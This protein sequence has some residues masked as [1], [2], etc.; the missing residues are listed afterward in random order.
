MTEMATP[1]DVP[2][3]DVGGC[4][5]M[6]RD[7]APP[8]P[9]GCYWDLAKELREGSPVYFNTFAQG[10]WIFTRHEAVKDI[11]K[12]PELFSS[13]SFTPWEP[14]P[15]YRF[16]P[17]Q[18][19]APDHI[20]Y[21]RI[22]NPWFSPRAI[23][24]AEDDLRV[25]CRGLIED[26]APK[27]ACDFVNEFA[28][29]FP[30][31][32]FL[33]VVGV[34]P[35]DAD[36]F[37]PWVE[38]F[39]SGFSGD[40]AGLEAMAKALGGIREDWGAALAEGRRDPEPREGDL[41]SHLLHSTFDDRPLT[42]DELLDMLTVLVLA[43]LDTTRATL[44]YIF[45]HLATHPAQRR[46]LVAEPELIPSAV[47]EALRYYPIVFGDGRKVTRDAEFH[48]VQLKKGDMVYALVA[49]ANRDPRAYERPDEF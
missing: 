47:E 15:V 39:F 17:T 44:G 2:P 21:R 40:P 41:A 7:F 45:W 14:N 16:V 30:T 10:Y 37:V 24:A 11:Y 9:A 49:G 13:E 1:P 23:D 33:H 4:P 27:G 38:D 12:T 18:I 35:Q 20:K 28:L 22:L 36:L 26:V 25:L 5:V 43:G 32:A 3:R 29:R 6:H 8:G 31:E 42:D 19:D 46:R 48:G 34:P